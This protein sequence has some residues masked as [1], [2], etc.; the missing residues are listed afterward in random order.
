MGSVRKAADQM[1]DWRAHGQGGPRRPLGEAERGGAKRVRAPLREPVE[2][3]YLSKIRLAEA[4][5]FEYLGE[6]AVGNEAVVRTRVV[7]R[8]APRF[9]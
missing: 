1:F 6:T 4:D 2:D 5:K 8:T 9:R 3:A 7:T